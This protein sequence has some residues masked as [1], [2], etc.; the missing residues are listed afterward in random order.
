MFSNLFADYSFNSHLYSFA[1][2]GLGKKIDKTFGSRDLANAYMYKLCDKYSLNIIKTY[3][4]NHD[5]TYITDKGVRF[6]IQRV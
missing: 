2:T 5:K 3:D 4:D 1:T 6:Y